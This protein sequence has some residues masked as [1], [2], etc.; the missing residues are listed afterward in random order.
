MT[1]LAV[2]A[3]LE[4]KPYAPLWLCGRT[5]ITW[6]G[7]IVVSDNQL[8]RGSTLPPYRLFSKIISGSRLTRKYFRILPSCVRA[9]AWYILTDVDCRTR[10]F[11][12][13]KES[14][15]VGHDGGAALLPFEAVGFAV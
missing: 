2:A 9:S 12:V 10:P 14:R 1:R 6:F 5:A 15:N 11:D 13:V 4:Q 3:G 8:L 7:D